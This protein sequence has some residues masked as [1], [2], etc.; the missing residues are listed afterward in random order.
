MA[1]PAISHLSNAHLADPRKGAK[2]VFLLSGDIPLS[3]VDVVDYH[4]REGQGGR[5]TRA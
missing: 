2:L 4:G 1:M 3:S 5:M